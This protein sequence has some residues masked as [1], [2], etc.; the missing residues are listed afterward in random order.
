MEYSSESEGNGWRQWGDHRRWNTGKQASA[1]SR[2][3]STTSPKRSAASRADIL[4]D[5]RHPDF[6]S[7]LMNAVSSFKDSEANSLIDSIS[8]HFV[9]Q[10]PA[11]N[12][13]FLLTQLL[14]LLK[15]PAAAA[16]FTARSLHFALPLDNPLSF[17]VLLQLFR[18]SPA[19]I[20]TNFEG[21][22]Q[23]IILADPRR[24]IVFLAYIAKH[25]ARLS[26]PGLLLD[27]LFT[28][29]ARFLRGRRGPKLIAILFNLC[30]SHAEYRADSRTVFLAGIATE[31]SRTIR[32][33]YRALSQFYEP[34][35]EIDFTKL[36]DH[37]Q[38]P[39]ISDAALDFLVKNRLLRASD[40]L[41]STLIDLAHADE[42]AS[43]VMMTL[44]S[45]KMAARDHRWV[46]TPCPTFE[47][48]LR[49]V[50]VIIGDHEIRA[51]MGSWPELPVLF[52]EL[53]HTRQPACV[54]GIAVILQKLDVTKD[55]L[56]SLRS[57]G[58]LRTLFAE[59]KETHVVL[60]A[61]IEI[62]EVLGKVDFA[63]EYLIL[64]REMK[65]EV[66]KGSEMAELCIR[67]FTVLSRYELCAKKF[68]DIGVVKLFRGLEDNPAVSA[69]AQVFL[70]NL[71]NPIYYMR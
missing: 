24:A 45:A 50:L 29:Q 61:A 1:A 39:R 32:A 28:N 17:S 59:A 33:S 53:C 49:M 48:T 41:V 31:D 6:K 69:D 58:L 13:A 2:P 44:P 21:R 62:M 18:F 40:E 19:S 54:Q 8:C 14:I 37:L 46:A 56:Q 26:N 70:A 51:T 23:E 47:H 60:E 67:A 71:S 16:A 55:L 65:E 3:L 66:A 15:N 38:S 30:S 64:S 35:I 63:P 36:A 9:R 34:S 12:F 57:S 43:L 52:S 27:L 68:V 25:C 11:S 4:S 22:M 5:W 7:E 20:E 10:I 42:R